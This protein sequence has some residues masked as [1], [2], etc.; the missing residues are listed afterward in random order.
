MGV[1]GHSRFWPRRSGDQGLLGTSKS[2]NRTWLTPEW[3][4]PIF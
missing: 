1:E 3:I 2:S 4:K